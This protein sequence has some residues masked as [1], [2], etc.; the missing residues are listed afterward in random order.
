[1]IN[2]G[3]FSCCNLSALHLK[4]ATLSLWEIQDMFSSHSFLQIK[5]FEVSKILPFFSENNPMQLT[6]NTTNLWK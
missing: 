2:Y 5:K 6:K 3:I 4:H 1:M